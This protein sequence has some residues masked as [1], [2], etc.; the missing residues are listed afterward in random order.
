MT[1]LRLILLFSLPLPVTRSIRSTFPQ[2][3]LSG[4]AVAGIVVVAIL[5]LSAFVLLLWLPLRR[6]RQSALS[7]KAS[8]S[9][10]SGSSSTNP[11]PLGGIAPYTLPSEPRVSESGSSSQT[12]RPLST[13][14]MSQTQ[15]LPTGAAHVLVMPEKRKDLPG[16]RPLGADTCVKV[17]G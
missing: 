1:A 7:E 15:I 3:S 8:D 17:A 6:T 4:G 11:F 12:R 2:S 14:P 10:E 13:G 9:P 16:M 5:A